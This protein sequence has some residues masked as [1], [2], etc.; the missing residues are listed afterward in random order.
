MLVRPGTLD[1]AP[2]SRL[3]MIAWGLTKLVHYLLILIHLTLKREACHENWMKRSWKWKWR[4][5]HR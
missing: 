3:L 4:A 5:R 1:E 2:R